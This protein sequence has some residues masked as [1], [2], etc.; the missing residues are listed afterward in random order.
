MGNKVSP[1]GW[2]SGQVPQDLYLSLNNISIW[3]LGFID[4]IVL[5]GIVILSLQLLYLL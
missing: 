4:I 2:R 5:L 3:F 1:R